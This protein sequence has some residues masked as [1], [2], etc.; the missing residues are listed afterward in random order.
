MSHS[1]FSHHLKTTAFR[2][3]VQISAFSWVVTVVYM[4]KLDAEYCSR[5]E[6]QLRSSHGYYRSI[7]RGSC[8][9]TEL[10]HRK[11]CLKMVKCMNIAVLT[12]FYV[13]FDAYESIRCQLD[14]SYCEK[15][16]QM[17][18]MDVRSCLT[19][20]LAEKFVYRCHIGTFPESCTIHYCS[21]AVKR[22]I[23]ST[24]RRKPNCLYQ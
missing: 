17:W 24:S 6:F 14:N 18:G 19:V 20:H 1:N 15:P 4:L 2:V 23:P 10:W 8:G 3:Y 11:R 9:H 5:A 7:P 22:Y 13:F 12:V 21:L 16:R